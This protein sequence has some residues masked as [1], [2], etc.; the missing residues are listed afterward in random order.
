MPIIKGH[1]DPYWHESHIMILLLNKGPMRK[2]DLFD[3]IR[4][5][6][7]QRIVLGEKG[8]THSLSA[9]NYWVN[10]RKSQ[11]VVEEDR[12]TLRLTPLGKWIANSTLD[13]FLQRDEFVDLICSECAKPEDLAFLKPLPDTAE[14]N[15]KGRLFMDLQCPRCSRIVKRVPV[16]QVLS[17]EEFIKFYNKALNELQ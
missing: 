10:R 5:E 14:T 7:R 13:T 15:A 17:K 16:S 1:I 2:R 6:Q 9:Y 11:Y 12:S 4:K 8:M 3:A